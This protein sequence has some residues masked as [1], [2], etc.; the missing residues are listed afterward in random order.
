MAL[1]PYPRAVA[2]VAMPTIMRWPD[3]PV[4]ATRQVAIDVADWAA[5][6]DDDAPTSVTATITP[7]DGGLSLSEEGVDSNVLSCTLVAHEVGIGVDYAVVLT[8]TTGAGRVEPFAARILVT[9]PL[10]E[11]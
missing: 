9:N 3:I 7:G 11:A 4:G 6:V 1:A 10:A 2:R 8:A 5:Q